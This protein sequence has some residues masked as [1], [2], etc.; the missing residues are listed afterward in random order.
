MNVAQLR[1]AIAGAP[2]DALVVIVAV[3]AGWHELRRVDVG[4]VAYS[5]GDL[6]G[7]LRRDTEVTL[8]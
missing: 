1:E 8:S 5:T 3:E 4:E 7:T 2:D 6:R